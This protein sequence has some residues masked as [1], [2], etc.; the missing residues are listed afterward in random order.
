MSEVKNNLSIPLILDGKYFKIKKLSETENENIKAGINVLEKFENYIKATVN[1]R[2]GIKRKLNDSNPNTPKQQK[3]HLYLNDHQ[4][5]ESKQKTSD[6]NL[7]NYIIC[8]LSLVEDEHFLKMIN[9]IDGTSKIF[10]RRT[11]SRRI[12]ENYTF[13]CEK[14]KNLFESDP[15]P[16]LCIT[17]DIWSARHKSFMGVTAHWIDETTLTRFSC[18]LA[19]RR[20]RGSHTYDKIAELLHEIICE[21]SIEREQLIS[22]VTDNG[23]HFVKAVMIM[24]YDY[25]SYVKADFVYEIDCNFQ[26]DDLELNEK[27]QMKKKARIRLHLKISKNYNFLPHHLRCASHTLSLIATTD[28]NNILKGTPASRINY[29]V[30]GKCTTL[31]FVTK[32]KIFRNYS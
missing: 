23:S 16:S 13:I 31:E 22:T 6:K 24:Q 18:L 3:L 8:P 26:T 30:M 1:E 7:L 25:S 20:F 21:F 19:C 28:F 11:L 32:T 12:L 29:S 5:N 2:R 4:K 27:I 17:A 9:D 14:L 10:S 15:R